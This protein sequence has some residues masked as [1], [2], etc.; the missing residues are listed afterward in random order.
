VGLVITALISEPGGSLTV[1]GAVFLS[2]LVLVVAHGA[3]ALRLRE[4][5]ALHH[6]F[7]FLVTAVVWF[8]C[9]T[10][11]GALYGVHVSLAA[12]VLLLAATVVEAS[13]LSGVWS[14]L[15]VRGIRGD[16]GGDGLCRRRATRPPSVTASFVIKLAARIEWSKVNRDAFAVVVSCSDRR[17]LE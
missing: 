6:Q 1:G 5:R 17:I 2:G 15:Y 16:A 3:A 7:L 14:G 10:W 9:W 11:G 8:G 13:A 4:L 12:S